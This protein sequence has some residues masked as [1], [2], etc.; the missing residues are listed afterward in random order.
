MMLLHLY[1][2]DLS[3]SYTLSIENCIH[4]SKKK[5]SQ[6]QLKEAGG[7]LKTNYMVFCQ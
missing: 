1:I 5:K 3:P 6:S 2:K 7:I 4:L